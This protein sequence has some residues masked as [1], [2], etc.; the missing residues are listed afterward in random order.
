MTHHGGVVIAVANLISYCRA[1]G[2]KKRMRQLDRDE[3]RRVITKRIDDYSVSHV[4]SGCCARGYQVSQRNEFSSVLF[5]FLKHFLCQ[6][7]RSE[8]SNFNSFHFQRTA[9]ELLRLPNWL[10]KRFAYVYAQNC[11]KYYCSMR[12]RMF[13]ALRAKMK[14]FSFPWNVLAFINYYQ[15]QFLLFLQ[16]ISDFFFSLLLLL[17]TIKSMCT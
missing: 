3:D 16:T 11:C 14:L 4:V 15:A 10:S 17:F 13:S 7:T 8:R 12:V 5:C 6:Q 9:N 1:T 2:E